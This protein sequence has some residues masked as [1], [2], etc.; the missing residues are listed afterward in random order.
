MPISRRVLL[1]GLPAGV[2]A[3][4]AAPLRAAALSPGAAPAG[5]PAVT[6]ANTV[7]LLAG[8]AA[9]SARPEAA[10][11]LAAIESTA[12]GRL[13]ALDAAGDGELFEG[14]PLGTSDPNLRASYQ[15]LYD[16]ALATRVPGA[17]GSTLRGDTAVQDRVID[18]LAELHDDW[19]GDQA[20]GYYGNWYTWEIGISS[21]VSR[22][23]VLLA[24]RLAGRLPALTAA[25]VASMDGYLRNGKDGDVDLDSRFHTGANLADI[26]TNR[27]LQGSVL[28]DSRRIAKAVADQLTVLATINP[29][30]LDHQVTDGFYADGSFLQHASVAYTGS[31]GRDL[32]GRVVDTVTIL[33]GAGY[34]DVAPVVAVARGWIVRSFAPV[35]FE[36]WMMEIVKGRGVSRTTSGYADTAA[37]IEAVVGLSG[38]AT[39][40]D[41]T[42]LRGYARFLHQASHAAPTPAG[43]VSPVRAV[44]YADILADT[45]LPARDLA[46][47]RGNHAFGAMDRTVHRRPGWAFALARSSTRVSAY[48]YM[49]GENLMP[50]FQGAGAH[51]LYLRGQDQAQRFGADH[52]ATVPPYRLAGV[53]APVEARRTVPQLYGTQWFDDPAAGFTASSDSQNAYVYFPR[54]T[55]SF[56]GGVSLDGFGT[57]GLVQGDDAAYAAQQAGELPDG[58]VAYRGAE[59]VKSWFLLDEEVVVLVA[60]AGD[61]AGRGVT[62]TLDTRVSDPADPVRVTGLRRDGRAWTPGEAAVPLAWLR[63]SDGEDGPSVGYVFLDGPPPVVS[64]ETVTRSRRLVRAANPDTPV[65]KRVFSV[66]YEQQPGAARMSAAYA[67]LPLACERRLS[68][69]GGDRHS[70][71]VLANTTRLQALAHRGLGL[72]ALNAFTSGTHR[73]PGLSVDGP[74]SVLVRRV[75]RGSVTV[76][77]GDPTTELDQVA[78][79]LHGEPLSV[80]SADDGVRVRRVPGGTRV[81]ADTRE[82]YGRS[83]TVTLR[84]SR[85]P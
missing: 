48:E 79:T 16:I 71:E 38:Y 39:G 46:G 30:H 62:T 75:D 43:F 67:L 85:R 76:A 83:L 61:A 22:T 18:A 17:A 63:W 10:A 9:S 74:V 52:L 66:A 77:F 27:V 78:V 72:T 28:A 69:Y 8:T 32:L 82:A 73:V 24:D 1:S 19:Y 58:F 12:R 35:I 21:A 81:V 47:A 14:L 36:G 7:A 70:P 34:T 56:S 53:T 6:A 80:V 42:A 33:D 15:Y 13:A 40:A 55:N 5:D 41:A 20:R 26:T 68:A 25:Y 44:R 29:Y 59:A 31:Y 23:L 11:R 4:A 45:S 54:S 64:L 50:W 65:T 2:L 84:A 57:A 3:A 37:I 49:S 51:H 60:G